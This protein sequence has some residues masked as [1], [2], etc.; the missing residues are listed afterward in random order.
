MIEKK[1]KEIVTCYA[2]GHKYEAEVNET[3]Y[4]DNITHN[5]GRMAEQAGIYEALWRPH[6]LRSDYNIRQ[7][8][9]T[10]ED[11]FEAS[12]TIR[13]KD[14][15]HFLEKGLEDLKKRPNYYEQFNSPNGWGLYKHFVPFVE[16]YLNAC[17]QYP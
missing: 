15:I 1:G 2:C 6:R 12:V 3:L 14:I 4:S 11:E 13:A 17:K 7:A 10:A 5:L 8:D 9:F 16:R